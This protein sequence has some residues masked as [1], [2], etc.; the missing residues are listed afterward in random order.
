MTDTKY[1]NN[2]LIFLITIVVTIY[3]GKLLYGNIIKIKLYKS[4]LY[5]YK[6]TYFDEKKKK[7]KKRKKKKEITKLIKPI[8]NNILTGPINKNADLSSKK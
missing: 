3:L 6:T 8:P 1:I 5:N 2:I 7:M 4:E